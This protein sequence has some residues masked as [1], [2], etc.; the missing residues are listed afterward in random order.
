MFPYR[1]IHKFTRTSPDGKMHNQIDHILI[2]RKWHSSVL[3]VQSFRAADCDTDDYLVVAEVRER[4]VVSKHTMHT[5][6]M[7]RFNLKKLNE[8]EGKEQY[9]VEISN[10]FTALVNLHVKVEIN[11]QKIKIS[12]KESQNYIF[13]IEEA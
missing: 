11:R 1:N 13:L 8:T 12:A 10:R 6:H 4:L 3:D 9:H 5:V 7:E 2:D